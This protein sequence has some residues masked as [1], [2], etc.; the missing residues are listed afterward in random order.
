VPVVTVLV[1]GRPLVVNAELDASQ[2]FVAAWLPGSEGQGVAEVLL[3]DFPF[4][5][6]LSFAWPQSAAPSYKDE[7]PR[8]A[9]GYGLTTG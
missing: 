8:F 9:R 5:G 7:A 2:A 4:H 1:A 3:G 6:T